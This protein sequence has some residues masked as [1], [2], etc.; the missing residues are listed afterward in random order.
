LQRWGLAQFRIF[1]ADGG[2]L[3]GQEAGY[4]ARGN[5]TEPQT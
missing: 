5:A 3:E 2:R 4:Y 1:R